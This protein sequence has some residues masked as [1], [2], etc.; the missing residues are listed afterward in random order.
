MTQLES[1][2]QGP[3]PNP[4]AL[5]DDGIANFCG[6]MESMGYFAGRGDEPFSEAATQRHIA[7]FEA[8]Q[9]AIMAA[10]ETPSL[11]AGAQATLHHMTVE[12]GKAIS[13]DNPFAQDIK[14]RKEI[15]E[16]ARTFLFDNLEPLAEIALTPDNHPQDFRIALAR[17]M[18]AMP[19]FGDERTKR[20]IPTFVDLCDLVSQTGECRGYADLLRFATPD[21]QRAIVAIIDSHREAGLDMRYQHADL[22]MAACHWRPEEAMHDDTLDLFGR[23]LG[24]GSTLYER[25]KIAYDEGKGALNGRLIAKV[26]L[27]IDQPYI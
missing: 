6:F 22:G 17:T 24:T 9:S 3:I 14:A 10:L 20:D 16:T 1:P 7:E 18:L 4:N 23:M 26:T 13:W 8:N 21:Q 15:C 5:T 2:N 27:D 25:A 11:Q 19:R 12:Y